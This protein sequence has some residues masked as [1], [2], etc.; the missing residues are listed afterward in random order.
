MKWQDTI[1]YPQIIEINH[2]KLQPE[3]VAAYNKGRADINL[4]DQMSP[5]ATTLRKGDIESWLSSRHYSCQ[6]L[7]DDENGGKQKENVVIF[8]F[9]E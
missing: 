2:P 5:Y 6:C 1:H 4:S 3:I 8:F 9:R 7:L